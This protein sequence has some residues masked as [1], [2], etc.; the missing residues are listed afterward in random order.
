[1]G[2]H[3]NDESVGEKQRLAEAIRHYQISHS[4]IAD[5]PDGKSRRGIDAFFF[6][7]SRLVLDIEI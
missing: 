2:R 7:F 1:M 4:S 6:A 3:V 5:Q